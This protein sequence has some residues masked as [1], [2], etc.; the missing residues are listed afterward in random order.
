[1]LR[2]CAIEVRSRC[3]T[4]GTENCFPQTFLCMST[5]SDMKDCFGHAC[6][7]I[8]NPNTC[9]L[10]TEVR[11]ISIKV[12]FST[13]RIKSKTFDDWALIVWSTKSVNLKKSTLKNH[14]RWIVPCVLWVTDLVQVTFANY[15]TKAWELSFWHIVLSQW[16]GRKL[17][18]MKIGSQKALAK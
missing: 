12:L 1:M 8:Y 10:P 11:A 2:W 7:R 15:E 18:Y 5:K 9:T 13:T 16:Y 6:N 14:A 3:W 17:A 4:R